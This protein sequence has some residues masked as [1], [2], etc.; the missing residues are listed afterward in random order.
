MKHILRFCQSIFKDHII[1]AFFFNARGESFEKTPLGMLCSLL[2][3]LLGRQPSIYERFLPIFRDKRRK[4]RAGEWEWRESELKEF[5][6]SEIQRPQINPLIL[7]VD[8][9][10]EC[11]ESDVRNVVRFLEELSTKAIG[12]KSSLNICLSSCHYPHIKMKKCKS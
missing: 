10:D 9:L 2:Y 7:L 3:Q 5:I 8:A 12:A 11:N 6:L 1:A 4:H